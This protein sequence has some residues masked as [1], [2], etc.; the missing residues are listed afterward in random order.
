ME[1]QGSGDRGDRPQGFHKRKNTA[2]EVTP[3]KVPHLQED[4]DNILMSK[5]VTNL[6]QTPDSTQPD[7]SPT[8]DTPT[9][10]P[11]SNTDP[12]VSTNLQ[13]ITK[14][15]SNFRRFSARDKK[16]TDFFIPTEF[17]QRFNVMEKPFKSH[18]FQSVRRALNFDRLKHQVL[19]GEQN[20]ND[21]LGFNFINNNDTVGMETEVVRAQDIAAGRRERSII[22]DSQP[23]VSSLLT[24]L[25]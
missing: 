4:M 19:P 9:H 1:A 24:L 15:L 8:E 12:L 23:H 21:D 10:S 7:S 5:E 14:D 25:A 3:K 6:V 16:R 18:S 22:R 17:P 20:H 11:L 13:M 2:S